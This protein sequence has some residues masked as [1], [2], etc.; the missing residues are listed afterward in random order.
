MICTRE[1]LE[2]LSKDQ[3][4]E[5]D[6]FLESNFC[7]VFHEPNFNIAV[8]EFFKTDFYYYLAYKN[9]SL[10]GLCPIH[11]MKNGNNIISYSNPA[12]YGAPY[13]G[14]IYSREEV[15]LPG[16]MAKI[17]LGHSESLTYWSIPQ[18]MHHDYA[19]LRQKQEFKTSIIDLNNN[20]DIIWERDISSRKRNKIRIAQ[21]NGI[22]VEKL[23][24]SCFSDY[25]HL[26]IETYERANLRINP[27]SYYLRILEALAFKNKSVVF[28]AR[29]KARL[30]AGVILLRNNYMCHYWSGAHLNDAGNE[31][32]G[33]LLQWEAI[34]W[35]KENK[36][37][38]YDLCVVE[39]ERLP[40]I[41]RF[42]LGFSKNLTP[43][44]YI[45]KKN[46]LFRAVNRIKKCIP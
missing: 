38:F 30:L 19:G 36:S 21:R 33:E 37:Q 43:F 25:Y 2:D 15:S 42:K 7:T 23:N 40:N 22:T 3:I 28:L 24:I 10:V 46:L 32:H 13:G 27:Q 5:I 44:Y 12:M 4:K 18:V 29:K 8:K 41:A 34:K 45:S 1:K 9:K 20:L 16:L 31:G 17:R 26:L 35:A 11:T 6:L 39:P 14:W